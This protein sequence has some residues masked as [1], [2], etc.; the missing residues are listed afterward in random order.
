MTTDHAPQ[1]S[2]ALAGIRHDAERIPLDRLVPSPG[3]V[4]RVNTT[5]GISGLADSIEAHGLLQNLT[6]RRA[7]R[8]R[9]EVV[10]GARRLAALRLLVKEGRLARDTGIP[11][12]ICT[13]D[14][15]TELSLAENVQRETMHIVDEIT[16]YRD[17]AEA[18]TPPDV[19]AARF[20]QSVVT[21]RQRLKLA[22]LSPKVLDVLR[23]DG[24]SIEQARALAIC[25]SHEAQ[26]RVWFESPSYHRDPRTLRAFLTSDHARSTDRLAR[27]VGLEAYEAAGGVVVRDLF[28]DDASAFL[29]DQPLLTRLAAERLEDTAQLLRTEGWKWVTCN[30]DAPSFFI[31][32]YGRIF[33]QPRELTDAEQ[34]ALAEITAEHTALRSKID[35]YS[36]DDPALVADE[37]R[38]YELDEKIE[39]LYGAKAYDPQEMALAGCFVSLD[40]GGHL[41]IGRGFV[42]ADDQQTLARLQHGGNETTPSETP[43]DAIP[44]EEPDVL[45]SAALVEELTAIRTAAMRVELANRPTV[46]LAALLYPMV[47]KLFHSAYVMY[48]TAVEVS[49]QLRALAPSLKDPAAARAFAAWEAMKDAW[50]DTL[51]GQ[52][53]DLWDWLLAQPTDKLLDLLAF[54]AAANLNAV[55]T[56]HDHNHGRLEN[57]EQVATAVGLDMHAHWSPDATFLS[58]LSKTGIAGVLDE[59][60]CAPEAVKAI[61][62]LPKDDAVSEAERLLSGN[63]WLPAALR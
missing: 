54:A 55:R 59:A 50:G 33:T 1:S 14:N 34:A 56:K 36:E 38:L 41:S 32:G 6:V 21:V 15:D 30:L 16:A 40:H 29:T 63:D 17:M 10:A 37:A 19:I 42:H 60:G 28:G 12:N 25:D 23:D 13:G 27:F 48:G 53:A 9:Y 31:S 39:T 61:A 52:A 4:R 5:A 18:G 3:N 49:G 51:P 44:T 35:S 43:Q 22:G 8:G 46:A 24:M 26:E 11:C 58:R 57:A 62:R 47:G 7:K 45:Y 20:G 2:I